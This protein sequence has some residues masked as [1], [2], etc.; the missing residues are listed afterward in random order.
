[1]RTSHES[2]VRSLGSGVRIMRPTS[3]SLGRILIVAMGLVISAGC[4]GGSTTTTPTTPTTPTPVANQVT[5]T[6]NSGPANNAVNFGFVSVQVCNPGSTTSCTTIPN[7]EVDTG[8]QGLRIL[9]SA[10]GVSGLT[11]PAIT[12]GTTPVYECIQ[13]GT[14]SYLWGPVVQAD[15]SMAGEKASGLPIQV[16]STGA[17]PL[18]VPSTCTAGGGQNLGT[19]TSLEANG[20][21]GIGPSIQDCGAA[22]YQTTV[23]PIYW[24]C[25][26]G[27]CTTASVNP[28]TQVSN[29][30]SFFDS[31]N[32]GVILA[33]GSVGA[34]GA[35]TASGTLTF[36]IGTQSDNALASSAKVYALSGNSLNGQ[37]FYSILATYNGNTYPA[38]LDTAEPFLAFLDPATV[39]ALPAGA[40]I[41]NCPLHNGL[42]C[43]SS[44]VNLPFTA[45]DSVGDSSTVTLAI[46]DATTLFNS[47]VLGSGTN[48]A[49]SNLAGVAVVGTSDY[50]IL[51]M[52]FFYSKTVYVGISGKVPPTG[53]SAALGYWAF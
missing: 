22:C 53:V 42:Y 21:L 46:G 27:G 35:A 31:D 19:T 18:N 11:L 45:K 32:N 16:I 12:G 30:V 43:T 13:F 8:S 25:P 52:P 51:G 39:A 26:A 14:G 37:L 4:G 3:A 15:V 44:A 6:V 1:M 10:P 23:P 48:A 9:A 24:L 36:G 28:V 33:M 29:P 50:V 49:F 5:V 40:G 41:T 2:G 34:T 7:V 17:T 47:S 38:F 20:I